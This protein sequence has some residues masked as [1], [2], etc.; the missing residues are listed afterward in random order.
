[1]RLFELLT[2]LEGKTIAQ[3]IE[4]VPA[5]AKFFF[6]N[7]KN[8]IPFPVEPSK[9]DPNPADIVI[10]Q[11]QLPELERAYKAGSM[12]GIMLQGTDG[13][14]ININ[15]LVKTAGFGTKEAEKIPVKPSDVFAVKG[16]EDIDPTEQNVSMADLKNLGAFPLKELNQKIQTNASLDN[17]GNIGK[18][19]REI[20]QQ[21]EDG[22]V[23][24]IPA[25]LKP[26]EI[27]AIELYASEYLGILSLYKGVAE[28]QNKGDFDK[29]LGANLGELLLYFPYSTTN[30][31]GDSFA[32]KNKQNGHTLIMSSKAGNQGGA[33]PA[34]S[35][36]KIPDY[37]R[38]DKKFAK[39]VAFL[40]LCQDK[41]YSG[42]TQPFALMNWLYEN[43]PETIPEQFY[44]YLPWNKE[45]IEAIVDGITD[46]SKFPKKDMD[47]FSS[48]LARGRS[49]RASDAGVIWYSTLSNVLRALNEKNALPN[50][51]A[52]VLETLGYN[53]LQV[54]TKVS[55]G[56][57]TTKI[58]WPA[59]I[60]GVVNFESKAG[61]TEPGKAKI[62]F[63]V[64]PN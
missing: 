4:K 3:S 17:A 29:F 58:F 9:K 42:K 37:L 22:Q 63:R 60:T 32:V 5:R 54:Y 51:N 31:L 20:S 25:Y 61:A 2:L 24:T 27:K 6:D 64:S 45:W 7:I 44:P 38:K 26:A 11:S 43:A 55:K 12:S 19:I 8:K 23:P 59:K 47:I 36:L 34:V 30:Q 52:A 33:A 21:I 16:Q 13:R 15:N 62:S 14:I 35:G 41:T 40:D 48:M 46:N 10:K 18:A 1:M 56:T 53:F 49:A 39:E 28:F 50:I 57:L